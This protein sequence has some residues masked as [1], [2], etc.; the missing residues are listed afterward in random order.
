[1][2]DISE[3]ASSHNWNLPTSCPRCGTKLIVNS[4]GFPE[5][6]N[7][8]C[9]AKTEHQLRRFFGLLGIKAAGPAFIGKA[10]EACKSAPMPL[11]QLLVAAVYNDKDLFNEWAGGINGEKVLKQLRDFLWS[12]D[13]KKEPKAVT[14]SMLCAMLD[15]P[16]LSVK[17]FDK[18]PNLSLTDALRGFS[19]IA[20]ID[21]PG[22][23]NETA[24]EMTRFWSAKKDELLELSRFFE[25]KDPGDTAH[26]LGVEDVVAESSLPT[27]CFTGACPG[28]S[29]KELAAKCAGK[30]NVVDSVTK[31][32]DILACADPSSSSSKLQK[33][34]KN[35]T[36]VISY[37]EL[38]RSLDA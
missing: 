37:E 1:M 13:P 21:I 8:S 9:I 10:A 20:L 25:V 17:Q 33:A 18:I 27:I 30:Y 6:P 19:Y 5:C 36:K 26:F 29:R 34:R 32:T 2:R 3:I 15:W 23:G 35:G 22:I 24:E 38:L 7:E 14:A 4:S 11:K 28:Y 16:G 12:S 31:D